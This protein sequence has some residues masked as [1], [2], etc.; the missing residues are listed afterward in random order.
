M[1][2]NVNNLQQKVELT[3]EI[4]KLLTEVAEIALAHAGRKN[5]EIDIT[6]ADDAYLRQ[7]NRNYRGIDAATDV[8]SFS[9]LETRDEEPEYEDPGPE[10][11]GEVVIS[12]ERAAAQAEEYGHPLERELAYLAV[13][14]VLHLL[15]YDHGDPLRQQNMRAEEE[16]ILQEQAH[17]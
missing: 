10:L 8:L 7:L 4:E 6:L 12:S 3:A 11:L 5:A 1:G 14:G 2:I 17:V 13:H 15:G 16:R 9:M